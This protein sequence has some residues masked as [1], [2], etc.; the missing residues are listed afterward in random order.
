MKA[1]SSVATE[2]VCVGV[3]MADTHTHAHLW[4]SIYFKIHIYVNASPHR[5]QMVIY[6]V[7]YAKMKNYI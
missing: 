3:C 5:I 1:Q 2:Y 6:R 7:K 4:R